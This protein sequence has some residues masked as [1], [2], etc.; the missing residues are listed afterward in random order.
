MWDRRGPLEDGCHDALHD[1][2]TA[3]LLAT[4]ICASSVAGLPGAADWRLRQGDEKPSFI[5]RVVTR[6]EMT[7]RLWGLSLFCSLER[8]G[9][10]A[11][12]PLTANSLPEA[13][14]RLLCPVGCDVEFRPIDGVWPLSEFLRHAIYGNE[15]ARVW[16]E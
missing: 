9:L 15:P 10:S 8:T 1:A 4:L 6:R 7:V 12:G 14:E 5:S 16:L 13:V 2:E 3:A 11:S